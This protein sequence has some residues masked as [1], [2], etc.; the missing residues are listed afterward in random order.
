MVGGGTGQPENGVN[1]GGNRGCRRTFAGEFRR[2][3]VRLV[4]EFGQD[5]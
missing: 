5:L 3:L 1:G 4:A 2:L